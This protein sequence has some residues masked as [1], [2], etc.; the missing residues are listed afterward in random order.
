MMIGP[1]G[2]EFAD[3]AARHFLAVLVDD[4]HLGGER[5]LAAGFEAAG[6][7]P[8]ERGVARRQQGHDR[9]RLGHAVG[10]DELAMRASPQAPC[11]A[12]PRASARRRRGCT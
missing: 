9:R 2:R 11:A 12:R 10:V 1:L 5:R 6:I 3:R 4:L 8:V 7:R